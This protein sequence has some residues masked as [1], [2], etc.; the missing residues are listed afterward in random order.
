MDEKRI[1]VGTQAKHKKTSQRVNGEIKNIK[2]INTVV[3]RF[4]M[5]TS[6]KQW[7]KIRRKQMISPGSRKWMQT[8][9]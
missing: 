5:V 8:R 9:E 1:E 2:H 3:T 4:L 7:K 6:F